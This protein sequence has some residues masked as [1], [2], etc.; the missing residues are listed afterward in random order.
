MNN[1]LQSVNKDMCLDMLRITSY[2]KPVLQSD[3]VGS[4]GC[5]VLVRRPGRSSRYRKFQLA[6]MNFAQ[7]YFFTSHR[8]LGL[9]QNRPLQ[10]RAL[11]RGKTHKAPSEKYGHHLYFNSSLK[12]KSLSTRNG[13][14]FKR[15][16]ESVQIQIRAGLNSIP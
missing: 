4:K 7:V 12:Y 5:D 16:Q 2:L 13:E 1:N 11:D 14:A 10:P 15:Y 8:N 9:T 3:V 6:S